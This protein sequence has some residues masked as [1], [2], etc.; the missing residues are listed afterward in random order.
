MLDLAVVIH[1]TGI[2]AI[3]QSGVFNRVGCCQRPTALD[4]SRYF[5]W[6]FD[7]QFVI[8]AVIL[9]CFWWAKG[10]FRQCDIESDA[11]PSS[12]RRISE[13]SLPEYHHAQ[14]LGAP[15]I[16]GVEELELEARGNRDRTNKRV[17]TV[18]VSTAPAP[19]PPRNLRPRTDWVVKARNAAREQTILS[20]IETCI[21][22]PQK[23]HRFCLQWGLGCKASRQQNSALI[24]RLLSII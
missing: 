19:T 10:V 9:D 6:L 4:V 18:T 20:C 17:E 16:L 21:G 5:V 15:S 7:L 1:F 22:N 8:C 3:T 12:G 14:V 23:P 2:I 24:F 11:S 13:E